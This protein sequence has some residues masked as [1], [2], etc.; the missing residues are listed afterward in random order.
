MKKILHCGVIMCQFLKK[1][2]NKSNSNNQQA[3]FFNPVIIQ[4][5]KSDNNLNVTN[6]IT[7]NVVQE[8]VD[9]NDLNTANTEI[10]KN[11]EGERLDKR[12]DLI[13]NLLA[14][15]QLVF[16]NIVIPLFEGV[17]DSW[18]SREEKIKL[19]REA[20]LKYSKSYLEIENLNCIKKKELLRRYIE[21]V[22]K[23][24]IFTSL[25]D[26]IRV[27]FDPIIKLITS[28]RFLFSEALEW[29]NEE[30]NRDIV[31]NPEKSTD[32]PK[33]KWNYKHFH[34]R[35]LESKECDKIQEDWY[36]HQF[37]I[38]FIK[39]FVYIDFLTLIQQ[40]EELLT[41]IQ[42]A[43]LKFQDTNIVTE[44]IYDFCIPYFSISSDIFTRELFKEFLVVF[45]SLELSENEELSLPIQ[46]RNLSLV[47]IVNKII[48]EKCYKDYDLKWLL[49]SILREKAIEKKSLEFL[50]RETYQ[51]PLYI[52]TIESC[53]L[54]E[55]LLI[56]TEEKGLSI[57]DIDLMS[58][59]QFEEFLCGYFNEQGYQCSIT[60][61]SGD[62]GVDL[63]AKKGDIIIAIQAKCY[64]GT[65]GNHAVMEAVAGMKYYNANRC[66]VITNSTFSKSAIELAKANGVILW[67]RQVL[68]EKING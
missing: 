10:Q 61:A 44:K 37:K 60:K 58:G 1:I 46:I 43:L 45:I 68:I 42:N 22:K 32:I 30:I 47:D 21:V 5:P 40:E 9:D 53:A 49:S 18:V 36:K 65:V 11:N 31:E 4:K 28:R 51:L 67:D 3:D 23:E 24:G 38:A 54:K 35:S 27:N 41:I 48:A 12:D 14:K 6:A 20:Y 15:N 63:I 33:W 2:F 19:I 66:M 8:V 62:Q 57:V 56:P 50:L 29:M 13:I 25:E 26:K 55:E 7:Q 59:V 16:L 34:Y 17:K 52:K 39:I 64:S